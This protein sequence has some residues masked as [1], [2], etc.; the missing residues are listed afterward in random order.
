MA[1]KGSKKK[2]SGALMGMR[3]GFKK[4]AGNGKK[5]K[6]KGKE[7]VSFQTVFTVLAVISLAIVF[8]WKFS[9]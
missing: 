9:Q 1:K 8:L 3:S 2:T 7:E 4:A 6:G 5:R